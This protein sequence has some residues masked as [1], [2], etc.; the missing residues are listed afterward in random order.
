MYRPRHAQHDRKLGLA[1]Q[2]GGRAGIAEHHFDI[3]RAHFRARRQHG[4]DSLG[5]HADIARSFGEE[6]GANL[7]KVEHSGEDSTNR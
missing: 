5:D 3:E 2:I 6:Q 1:D 4:I 7:G